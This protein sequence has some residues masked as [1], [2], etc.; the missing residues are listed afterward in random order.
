MGAPVQTRDQYLDLKTKPLTVPWQERRAAVQRELN[1][2]MS[3]RYTPDQ[4]LAQGEPVLE[5][6]ITWCNVYVTDF[7]RLMG[8]PAPTHWVMQ[9]GS[10]AAVGKGLELRA[11]ALIDWF[12]KHGGRYGW[13]SADSATAQAAAERGH[14]VV[15]GWK[16]P[17]PPNPGHV[18]IV[19]GADRITQAGGKNHFVCT[20]RMGFGRVADDKGLKYFV[21][22]DRP[23]GH[24]G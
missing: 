23:G 19:L 11:N 16:N 10:P 13:M 22:M 18:A 20:V 14:L 15:V 3:P 17:R 4:R 12:D 6:G 1:V 7:I 8:V 2:E 9:D 24:N 5:P 21:Q